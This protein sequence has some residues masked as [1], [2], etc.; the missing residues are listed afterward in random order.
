MLD[1]PQEQIRVFNFGRWFSGVETPPRLADLDRIVASFR[2]NVLLHEGAELAGPLAAAGAGI[3]WVTLGFGLL[4]PPELA[5][6]AGEALAPLWKGRG[7]AVPQWGGLYKYLYVDPYPPA[8]QI[9]AIHDLPTTIRIRPASVALE[10]PATNRVVAGRIYVTFGT[11][12]N[13]GEA[14]RQRMRL[15]VAGSADAAAEVIVTVGSETDPALLG[16]QPEH[17]QVRHFIPQDELLATCAGMVSHGGS[18]TLMGALCWRVPSLLLPQ[19]ADQFHNSQRAVS[20]GVALALQPSEITRETVADR[21]RR[22]LTAT[23]FA[24]RLAQVQAELAAAEDADT[25]LDQIEALV[26][27]RPGPSS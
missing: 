19:R 5:A 11:V 20:A 14:A 22:L 2:P 9:D 27:I 7:M 10:H 3:P 18:G 6:L 23:G 13:T 8:L 15:T 12:W 21:V 17:V 25:V 4:P 16:P 24:P 26:E 1:L